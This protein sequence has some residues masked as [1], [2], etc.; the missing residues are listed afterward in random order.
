MSLTEGLL[1][2]H[3]NSLTALVH[4]F[5]ETNHVPGF[6]FLDMACSLCV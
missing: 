3:L 2:H 4:Q 5:R 1:Q 6:I